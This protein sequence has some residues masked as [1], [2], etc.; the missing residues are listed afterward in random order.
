MIDDEH[1]GFSSKLGVYLYYSIPYLVFV[2]K[3]RTLIQHMEVLPF[4]KHPREGRLW[5]LI[6]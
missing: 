2:H 4:H 3:W 1:V 5:T 6:T